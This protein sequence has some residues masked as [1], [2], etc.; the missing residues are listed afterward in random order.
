MKW[1]SVV[2]KLSEVLALV[3][4]LVEWFE[5]PENPEPP[6]PLKSLSQ[7]VAQLEPLASGEKPSFEDDNDPSD[8]YGSYRG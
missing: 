1:L 4:A 3:R 5:R 6:E 8:D 2:Q 7:A